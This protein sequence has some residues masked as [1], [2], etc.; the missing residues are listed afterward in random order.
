MPILAQI[1]SLQNHV[2][3]PMSVYRFKVIIEDYEVTTTKADLRR[4]QQLQ[5]KRLSSVADEAAAADGTPE[6]V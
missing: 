6:G 1:S 5:F 4:V 2:P 3:S